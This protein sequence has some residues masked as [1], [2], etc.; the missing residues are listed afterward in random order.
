MKKILIVGAGKF[1]VPGIMKAKKLGYYVIA[2]DGNKDAVGKNIADEFHHIDVTDF[3]K[4]YELAKN[5][6]IDGICSI[7]SEVSIETVSYISE[8]MNLVGN[9]LQIAKRSHNKAEYY[10]LFKKNDIKTPLT[11]EYSPD[12]INQFK[13]GSDVIVKPSKGSGSRLVEK[14]KINE[15]KEYVN[16]NSKNLNEDEKF[17]LQEYIPGKEI[18]VDGFVNSSKTDILAI[19]EE[20]CD[21]NYSNNVSSELI[22]PPNISKKVINEIKKITK[23]IAKTININYGPIHMEYIIDDFENVYIIDFA[24]RGGGFR[25]FTDII[26]KTSG[27]DILDKYIAG[28]MGEEIHLNPP[29]EFKPVILKFIYS[30]KNGIIKSIEKNYEK[31]NLD[32]YIID[33]LKDVGD[34]V[35]KP[36]SGK[37][38]LASIIV[39]GD[40]SEVIQNKMSELIEGLDFIID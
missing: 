32:N 10:R 1:Q 12:N 37:D 16:K 8:K 27:V 24:L 4:N 15:I 40:S 25:L 17:L 29:L 28:T 30:N 3:D 21:D 20:I 23:K 39:W 31:N 7:A 11:V 19:S 22:F 33:L 9:D 35:K 18:T 38:R 5:K 34:K 6:S 2:T 14:L 13:K 26:E 36:I